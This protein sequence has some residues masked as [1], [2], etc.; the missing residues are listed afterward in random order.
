MKHLIIGALIAAS[1]INS[2]AADRETTVGLHIG[3]WHSQPGYNNEN[4]GLYV[5][6]KGWVLGAY[7]NSIKPRCWYEM[8]TV[9][10]VDHLGNPRQADGGFMTKC[11]NPDKITAYAGYNWEWKTSLPLVDSVGVTAAL[12]TGYPNKIKGTPLSLIVSPSATIKITDDVRARVSFLPKMWGNTT[13]VVHFSMEK[14]F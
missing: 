11:S 9:D 6:H 14:S 3:S 5:Q 7:R 10:F 13:A 4:F 1:S 8:E 2:F 12:A